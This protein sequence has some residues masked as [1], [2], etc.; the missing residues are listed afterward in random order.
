M[1]EKIS[2]AA[3]RL[4]SNVSE[5]RRGFLVR[6]GQAAV[7]VVGVLGGL[8]ALP[9]EAQAKTYGSCMV[10]VVINHKYGRLNGWCVGSN[11]STVY[12][13]SQCSGYGSNIG[14]V[15]GKNIAYSRPCSF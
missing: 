11:C 15:C 4:A 9:T 8:L 1:F 7:G 5:S 13:P 12:T 10:G 14:E 2:N 3:E 6:V